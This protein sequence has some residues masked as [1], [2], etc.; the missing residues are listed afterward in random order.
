MPAPGM[1]VLVT[2]ST[3]GIGRATAKLLLEQGSEVILHG[4]SSEKVRELAH[5]FELVTGTRPRHV[6]AD[7]SS[8]TSTASM[9]RALAAELPALDVIVNN[10]GA[11]AGK[12]QDAREETEEGH[13]KRFA[14]NYLAP[15]VLTELWLSLC[16]R[17]PKAILN[18]ASSGQEPLDFEDLMSTHGY[19]GLRAYRR[20]KLALILWTFDLAQ[21]YPDIAI[22]AVHP[23]AMLDTK[24]VRETFGQSWGKPEDGARAIR[25]VL[26]RSLDEQLTGEY[27]DVER[28]ARANAQ[29]YDDRARGALRRATETL[30]APILAAR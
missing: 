26:E 2:G 20:S 7:L 29:A 23:G 22:N 19:E 30:L 18:V 28:T 5:E 12:K 21:K 8:L 27:F 11:G 16:Q 25:A 15:V 3:D 13:E 10:A 24:I 1:K 4:R 9:V 6:V 14:V 17:P